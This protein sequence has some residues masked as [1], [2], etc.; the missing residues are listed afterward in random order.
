MPEHD[1]IWHIAMCSRV[2][3]CEAAFYEGVKAKCLI[4]RGVKPAL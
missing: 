4:A 3:T 1:C 2:S